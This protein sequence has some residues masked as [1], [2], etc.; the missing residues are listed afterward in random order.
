MGK[1]HKHL[2]IQCNSFTKCAF[3]QKLHLMLFTTQYPKLYSD[4]GTKIISELNFFCLQNSVMLK[5]GEDVCD[6]VVNFLSD[7]ELLDLGFAFDHYL[8]LGICALIKQ[9]VKHFH[10]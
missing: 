9:Y 10:A 5:N 2:Q 8:S 6:R 4:I 7:S 3:N 1:T